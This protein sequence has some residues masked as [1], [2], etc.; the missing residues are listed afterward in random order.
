M[1]R[2]IDLSEMLKIE[3]GIYLSRRKALVT[4]KFLY[5]AEIA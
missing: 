5:C 1:S 2:V 4:E 3:V